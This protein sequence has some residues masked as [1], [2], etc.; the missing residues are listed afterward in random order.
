MT[1]TATKLGFVGLGLMGEKMASRLIKAGWPLTVWNRAPD[2]TQAVAALGATVAASPAELANRSAVVFTCVTDT[3]AVEQVLFGPDGIASA[4]APG[5]IV[6]DHSTI[7]PMAARRFAERLRKDYAIGLIDAPVTG[8]V[9]GAGEGTLAIFAGGEAEDV[10]QVRPIVAAFARRFLH[11][12]ASG[13]GQTTKM[14][15]QTMVINTVA[16]MAEMMRLAENG[17][18]DSAR[19]PDI[20]SGGFADSRVLQV[21]GERMARR[22]PVVSSQLNIMLKDLDLIGAVAKTTATAMPITAIATELFRLAAAKGLGKQDSVSL[23]RI[24]DRAR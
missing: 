20:L 19:L 23:I 22:D 2:K 17:G 12:G 21:F 24:Y 1:D 8:G 16:V 9:I 18:V 10:E 5:T 6:V 11:M 15:N 3:A 13:A 7:E 4:A 14:C